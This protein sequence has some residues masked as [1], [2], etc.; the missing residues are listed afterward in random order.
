MAVF[1]PK[2]R[3]TATACPPSDINDTTRLSLP[4]LCWPAHADS[5]PSTESTR[6]AGSSTMPHHLVR[7]TVGR[8]FFSAGSNVPH[9]RLG[10][11]ELSL[12]RHAVCLLAEHA[13]TPLFI[14]MEPDRCDRP[15]ST[16]GMMQSVAKHARQGAGR[17]K[18]CASTQGV[19]RLYF[20]AY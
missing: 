16:A 1:G 6:P 12:G 11:S 2:H 3:S 4:G 9:A 15:G 19:V 10:L 14:P 17:W 5:T 13:A 8:R 18:L 20:Q 7:G